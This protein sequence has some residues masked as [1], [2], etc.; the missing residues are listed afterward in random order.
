MNPFYGTTTARQA[1]AAGASRPPSIKPPL[2][3]RPS[4]RHDKAIV[5]ESVEG[6]EH[7]IQM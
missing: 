1:P 3:S 6:A 5:I 4:S 2:A 7:T